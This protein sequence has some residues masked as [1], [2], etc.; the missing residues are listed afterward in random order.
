M[1]TGIIEEIGTIS[2]IQRRAAGYELTVRAQKV[3]EGTELGHSIA[4][5]GVCLTVTHLSSNTFTVGVSPET[6]SRTNLAAYRQ[7]DPVNLERALTPSSRMGGHFV[8]GH[9]DGTGTLT[10]LR[11]EEDSL[12]LTITAPD[13]IMHYIV[14]KGFIALDG[15][16]LTVVHADENQF[17][18]MLVAYTQQQITLG[19][20]KP[21]YKV[22]IEVDVLGKYVEAI[23]RRQL[24]AGKTLTPEFLA[25]HGYT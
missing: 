6:R 9:I 19:R 18:V 11:P 13:E 17:T 15:V 12:W 1:F 22:N 24:L 14:P 7:G 5:N 21:G 3:L 8:Q 20:Q 23:V 25:E 10:A 4:V 16:S 2:R